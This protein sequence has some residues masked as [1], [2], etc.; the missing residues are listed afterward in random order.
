VFRSSDWSPQQVAALRSVSAWL[1][2]G[3]GRPQVYRLFGYAGT[4]KTTLAK[5]I[6]NML[7]GRVLF[8]AFTGKAAMV[9]RSKGCHNASTI[10]SMIY[11][12]EENPVTGK[13]EFVLNYDSDVRTSSLVIIDE[14]SMVN[15]ELGA[16]LL[17]FGTPVL[18][19]GDPAQLPP[20][21]GAGFFTEGH[22]PDTMLTEIHRQAAGNPIIALATKVRNGE[23]PRHGSYGS[24]RVIPRAALSRRVVMSAD[25]VIVGLN[26]TRMS[27]NQKIRTIK[28]ITSVAPVVGE[29]LVCLKNWKDPKLLNGSLWEVADIKADETFA[30]MVV[31]AE[32]RM[33]PTA[34]VSVPMNFFNGTEDQLDK[35]L[36]KYNPEFTFGYALTCHK[37]QGSQWR[38][39][40]VFDEANAFREDRARW[41]YTAIT[42]AADT[43]TLV[44]G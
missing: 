40:V 32:E 38:N 44:Q 23:R 41:L 15:E 34:E 13:V 19:L 31:V 9:L 4:G 11:K 24:T 5:E 14:C 21:T 39:L 27:V 12:P 6:A 28:G 1:K 42:R 8:G 36:K 10:H 25:Q 3:P 17:S 30:D 16:D 43:L 20:V 37:S 7:R 35:D 33:L 26:R 2:A 29:K 22:T 18:V